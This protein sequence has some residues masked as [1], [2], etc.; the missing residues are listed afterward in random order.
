MSRRKKGR[1]KGK[2]GCQPASS[3]VRPNRVAIE[4][5]VSDGASCGHRNVPQGI[6]HLGWPGRELGPRQHCSAVRLASPPPRSATVRRIQGSPADGSVHKARSTATL[7]WEIQQRHVAAGGSVDRNDSRH[8]I[9]YAVWLDNEPGNMVSTHGL[10]HM[11]M[12]M[13]A[14][15]NRVEMLH[16]EISQHF[17]HIS[18][19]FLATW[20]PLVATRKWK[21]FW[22][23]RILARTSDAKSAKGQSFPKVR[24]LQ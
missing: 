13:D 3:K 24:L 7:S 22:L 15:A 11:D 20:Y 6:V 12:F 10:P 8:T 9:T 2:Q 14:F 19:F 4:C 5:T 21:A 16:W 1:C 23:A 18:T 17:L